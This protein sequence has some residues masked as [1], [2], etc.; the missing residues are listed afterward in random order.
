M[1]Y[2]WGMV[3]GFFN[4]WLH[5][6]TTIIA[7]CLALGM[8]EVIVLKVKMP[9]VTTHAWG[10]GLVVPFILWLFVLRIVTD[11]M[12]DVELELN[13]FLD[14]IGGAVCGLASAILTSGITVIGL[15]F[16]SL[17]VGAGGVSASRGRHRGP[18]RASRRRGI[19]GSRWIDGPT[20]FYGWLSNG[21]FSSGNDWGWH[22]PQLREQAVLFRMRYDPQ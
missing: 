22:M 16:T 17:P 13:L 14:K 20:H 19:Y 4:A 10:A 21:V 1:V 15:N 18:G 6:M 5:L 12:V 9:W 7:A 8:W 3:Q 11:K 2:W